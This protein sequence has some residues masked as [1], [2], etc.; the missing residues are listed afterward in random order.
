MNEKRESGWDLS[1]ARIA[2]A[3]PLADTVID[4]E[5]AHRARPLVAAAEP[6][7]G[8]R[9]RADG[10][11]LRADEIDSD[12]EAIEV[13]IYWGTSLI[14]IAHLGPDASYSIGDPETAKGKVDFK[15]NSLRR[16]GGVAPLFVFDPRHRTMSFS[17]YA[18][19][20]L[21][22]HIKLYPVKKFM[23]TS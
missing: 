11:P 12:A 15:D 5:R 16:A 18:G 14:Q 7:V 22:E 21:T 23:V 3:L 8:Y 1:S 6:R 4:S 2:R 20:K 9:L 13:R 17:F 10:P 19:G